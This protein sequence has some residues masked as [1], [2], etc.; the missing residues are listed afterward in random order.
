L[1]KRFRHISSQYLNDASN[2]EEVAVFKLVLLLIVCECSNFEEILELSVKRPVL[3]CFEN[4]LAVRYPVIVG[5]YPLIK[6]GVQEF[7]LNLI[8]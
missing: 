6:Y 5:I 8:P 7:A 4:L 1:I 2:K 3:R